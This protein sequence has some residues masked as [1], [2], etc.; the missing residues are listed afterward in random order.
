M[1]QQQRAEVPADQNRQV[2]GCGSEK[3]ASPGCENCRGRGSLITTACPTLCTQL[4]ESAALQATEETESQPSD[5]RTLV[6]VCC[7]HHRHCCPGRLCMRL[8]LAP[9]IP[10]ILATARPVPGTEHH[11]REKVPLSSCEKKTTVVGTTYRPGSIMQNQNR[12]GRREEWVRR[13]GSQGRPVSAHSS[14]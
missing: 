12:E 10:R 6:P 14:P 13:V 11:T 5:E 4:Q 7:R 2:V 8:S 3:R 9:G 1:G